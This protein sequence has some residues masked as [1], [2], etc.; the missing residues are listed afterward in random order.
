MH[1][2]CF[3]ENSLEES[4]WFSKKLIHIT[5]SDTPS[6]SRRSSCKKK[7]LRQ[8]LVNDLPNETVAAIMMLYKNRKVNVR[9]RNGNRLLWYCLKYSKRWYFSPIPVHNRPRLG[10]LNVDRFNGF[11][12]KK[13]RSWRY[14]TQTITD[15]DYADDLALLANTSTLNPCSIVWKRHQAVLALH[16][17]T[18]KTEY[19]CLNQ[20]QTTDIS[21]LPGGSFKLVDT[22]TY[23]GSSVLSTENL[24]D[25]WL[26][27]AWPVID[28]I[29]VV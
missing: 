28:R 1:W 16:T 13:W 2:T 8:H 26:V 4:K 20:N 27:K 7:T 19:T 12:L 3:W 23:L 29:L 24:F 21:T 10:A 9:S 15:A 17:N 14:S 6:N 11:T 22:F 18:E 5:Y 25:T